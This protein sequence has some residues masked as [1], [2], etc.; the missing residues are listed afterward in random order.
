MK[1]EIKKLYEEYQKYLDDFTFS[2]NSPT[3]LK[4]L[5][6]LDQQELLS[7]PD[8]KGLSEYN[9]LRNTLLKVKNLESL[10]QYTGK[11]KEEHF[12]EAKIIT[13]MFWQ[14][15]EAL[16]YKYEN[17][18]NSPKQEAN[19]FEFDEEVQFII[20]EKDNKIKELENKLIGQEK[21]HQLE[22]KIIGREYYN[23]SIEFPSDEE[24][25]LECYVSRDKSIE[26]TYVTGFMTGV[27]W[28]RK[29]IKSKLPSFKTEQTDGV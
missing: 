8:N 26:N 29:L 13:E 15:N 23:H 14:I 22:L 17:Q 25:R 6:W 5:E 2:I 12:E 16:D 24:I 1:N 10:I 9:K 27:K 20:D 3:P 7:E 19:K 28:V 18:T 11:I 21:A 4:F